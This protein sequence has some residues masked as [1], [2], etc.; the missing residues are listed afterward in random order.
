MRNVILMYHDVYESDP[1]ES[2]FR[3]ERDLPYKLSFDLFKDQV[4]KINDYCQKNHI[5]KSNVVFTFDDGGSSFYHLIADV[6][7]EYGYKGHFYITTKY[8]G[9]DGFLTIDEIKWL[10]NRGHF[11]GSH[12]H[13][14]EHLYKLSSNQVKQEWEKS[15]S[16]LSKILGHPVVE[17]SIPNGDVSE[18]V[19]RSAYDSGLREIYTSRPTTKVKNYQDMR[20]YGR[21]VILSDTTTEQ[22]LSIIEDPIMRQKLSI[23]WRIINCVKRIL[24]NKYL[25]LKNLIY[26]NN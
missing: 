1:F 25:Y 15:V 19:L 10:E 18:I 17:A 7:E 11:I 24:G 2:G 14:H 12:A 20:I 23:Q 16:V 21:Y 22:I 3:R 5:D 13:T 9:T 6:L 26:R 4:I 8:V